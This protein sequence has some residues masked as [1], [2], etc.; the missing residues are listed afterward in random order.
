MQHVKAEQAKERS[1]AKRKV[2]AQLRGCTLQSF[3]C[4]Q[5][6]VAMFTIPFPHCARK[7]MYSFGAAILLA[8][9]NPSS[10]FYTQ[11]SCG[12]AAGTA[13]CAAGHG[14]QSGQRS[15]GICPETARRGRGVKECK[16]AILGGRPAWLWVRVEALEE[17][18]V[19]V[20]GSTGAEVKGMK[21]DRV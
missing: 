9:R 13:G 18:D 6:N 7:V 5:S 16:S 17:W 19:L 10:L 12:T 1:V 15:D 2:C 20:G 11:A 3:M 14:I 4:M 21:R 8:S